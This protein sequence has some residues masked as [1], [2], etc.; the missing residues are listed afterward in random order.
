MADL[1]EFAKQVKDQL[2]RVTREPHWESGEADRYMV[3]INARRERFAQIANRLMT[4][5]IQPRLEILAECFSNATPTTNEPSGCCSYWFGYCE[6]FP[7]STK[8]SFTVEHDVRFENVVL[9]SRHRFTSQCI[10]R[11]E[12]GTPNPY[13]F[14]DGRAIP[15][16]VELRR[17]AA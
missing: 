4:S 9:G 16:L 17:M 7:T 1:F 3:K 13:R 2:T 6:R 12:P 5:A 10:G 11:A 15:M 8:V 14:L